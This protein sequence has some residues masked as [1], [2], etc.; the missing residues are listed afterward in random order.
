MLFHE[1][2]IFLNVEAKDNIELFI[3]MTKI[4]RERNY[5]KEGYLQSILE[6][7][8]KYPTGLQFEGYCVA[9]PHT[10][11]SFINNQRIV[12]VRLK[13]NIDF[14]EMGSEDN[15]L[16]IKIIF[17]LLINKGDEQINTLLNL[18]KLLGEKDIYNFLEKNAS[19]KEIY[20]ML[21]KKYDK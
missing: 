14:F 6:R 5:V 11:S 8:K 20:N 2:D 3:K 4:F 21:V 1:D 19:E 15:K 12:F 9:I 18:M 10:D 16:K 13:D 7:E 17:M